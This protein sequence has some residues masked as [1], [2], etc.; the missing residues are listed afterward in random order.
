M[1]VSLVLVVAGENIVSAKKLLAAEGK[2]CG[3]RIFFESTKLDIVMR[4]IEELWKVEANTL[5]FEYEGKEISPDSTLVG[6][7]WKHGDSI[8]VKMKATP[9]ILPSTFAEDLKFL[10]NDKESS[11]FVFKFAAKGKDKKKEE[12]S[13]DN[14]EE[15]NDRIYAHKCVLL[16]RSEKFRAMFKSSMKETSTGEVVIE[17]HE[18]HIFYAL[19]EYLYTDNLSNELK[20][21]DLIAL[22]VVA[23]EYVLPRLK[24][25]CEFRLLELISSVLLLQ[26]FNVANLYDLQAL[27]SKCVQF[28]F[29]H[30]PELRN[31][32]AS[33]LST[34][35]ELAKM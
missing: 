20:D 17:N 11:D 9:Q 16:C 25:L 32:H 14:V 7:N 1:A 15:S 19:L 28:Y 4:K 22:L 24:Q 12:T 23:D 30:L 34:L 26:L 2:K 27:K 31:V 6:L 3:F 5:K 8:I 18:P 29:L 13:L 35:A 21:E 33:Q 10:L